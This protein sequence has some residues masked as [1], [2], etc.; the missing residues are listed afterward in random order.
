MRAA[1][2]REVGRP[3]VIEELPKPEAGP[4]DMLI[5]VERSGI[6]ATEV[7][8]TADGTF[9]SFLGRVLGHEYAGVVVATGADVTGFEIGDRITAHASRGCGGCE[10]C[11]RGNIVLCAELGGYLGGYGEYTRAPARFSLKLPDNLSAA[12]GA[13]IEP[14]AVSLC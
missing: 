10:A 14:L 13:L 4:G 12:D 8:A 5:R 1:V 3:L 11:R 6:C 2:F 9:P 7:A